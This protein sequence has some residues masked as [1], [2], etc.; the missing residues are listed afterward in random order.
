[1]VTNHMD[2][3]EFKPSWFN[4][5]HPYANLSWIHLGLFKHHP[6]YLKTSPTIRDPSQNLPLPPSITSAMLQPLAGRFATRPST[7]AGRFI[8]AA[9]EIV[10]D[11]GPLQSFL[12]I[13]S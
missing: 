10:L 3:T 13:N 4:H 8:Q 2:M 6:K 12:E 11:F 7:A 1:M 5:I 9:A